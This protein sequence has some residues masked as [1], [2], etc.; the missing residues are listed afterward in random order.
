M[1]GFT[2][3]TSRMS[4]IILCRNE[5]IIIF[6]E[7]CKLSVSQQR[8]TAI[9]LRFSNTDW[10]ALYCSRGRAYWVRNSRHLTASL[11]YDNRLCQFSSDRS[12]C[13]AKLRK[14]SAVWRVWLNTRLNFTLGARWVGQRL[15]TTSA[16]L[17][18]VYANTNTIRSD[19]TDETIQHRL[20]TAVLQMACSADLGRS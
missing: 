1:F 3:E 2:E 5:N 10:S 20:D 17:F 8:R 16:W 11:P 6:R 13:T 9:T 19:Y 15:V 7:R 4:H 12:H 14:C 18:A